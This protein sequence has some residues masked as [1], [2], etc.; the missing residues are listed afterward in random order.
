MRNAQWYFLPHCGRDIPVNMEKVVYMTPYF[1]TGKYEATE[2][3][4]EGGSSVVIHEKMSVIIEMTGIKC[5]N[6]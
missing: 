1:D 5:L 6:K 2:M 3:F 4:F